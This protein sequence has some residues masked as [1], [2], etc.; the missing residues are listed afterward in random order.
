[1][2][3]QE[4]TI[5]RGTYVR[6]ATARVARDYILDPRDLRKAIPLPPAGF[7]PVAGNRS[8]RVFKRCAPDVRVL[9][10]E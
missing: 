8:W 10:G 6:P 4:R 1:V 9:R 5:A 7:N 2:S 3:L